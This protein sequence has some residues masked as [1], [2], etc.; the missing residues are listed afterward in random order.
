MSR[1]EAATLSEQVIL[2]VLIARA[3]V[4]AMIAVSAYAPK[5]PAQ[6]RLSADQI[7]AEFLESVRTIVPQAAAVAGDTAAFLAR[8]QAFG[9]LE[10]MVLKATSSNHASQLRSFFLGIVGGGAGID[11]APLTNRWH[12]GPPCAGA[13]RDSLVA[14]LGEIRALVERFGTMPRV[15]LVAAWPNGG[16]RVGLLTY[17]GREFR[18]HTPSPGMGFVP[19]HSVVVPSDAAAELSALGTTR[20]AVEDIVRGLR[21]AGLAAIARDAVGSVRVVLAG[22]ISD[23]EAGLLFLSPTDHL[24]TRENGQLPDGREYVMMEGVAERVYFY[25]TT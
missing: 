25:E 4:F 12:C 7:Q 8:L 17:D 5:A 2:Q 20:A 23:N 1:T 14:H 18:L 15:E 11:P 24:P 6:V 21:A 3:V 10:L 22:G 13:R 19:W 16:Y 9:P